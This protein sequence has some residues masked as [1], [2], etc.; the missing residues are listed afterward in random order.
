MKKVGL[1][2]LVF[3]L[4]ACHFLPLHK[5]R[6]AIPSLLTAPSLVISPVQQKIAK[7]TLVL[8]IN[9]QTPHGMRVHT[10]RIGTIDQPTI[11]GGIINAADGLPVPDDGQT[12]VVNP[13]KNVP[14]VK[15]MIAS[16]S[17]GTTPQQVKEAKNHAFS[18]SWATSKKIE[19]LLRHAAKNGK[20]DYV[21]NQSKA[22]GLPASVALV[23]IIESQYHSHVISSKGAAGDWQ[24]MPSVASDYGI[25]N[26]ARFQFIPSTNV[27]LHLLQHLHQQFGNWEL[28]FAAYNAGKQRVLAALQKNPHAISMSHLSLPTQTKIYVAH[29]HDLSDFLMQGEDRHEPN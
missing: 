11:D 9:Y 25:S 14:R 12:S 1:F 2:A 24:L 13:A 18:E 27:A 19:A 4:V 16:Q 21:L 20:L 26:A 3:L 17:Q 29:L 5:K 28:T 23:P 8:P 7:T 22:M 10:R 15:P 6:A